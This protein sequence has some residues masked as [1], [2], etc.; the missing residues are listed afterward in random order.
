MIAQEFLTAPKRERLA[1]LRD[2][3]APAIV[4]LFQALVSA[5]D[6]I[7][8][9]LGT[10]DVKMTDLHTVMQATEDYLDLVA[11]LALT[12]PLKTASVLESISQVMSQ[13]GDIVGT[14]LED[15]KPDELQAIVNQWH[16]DGKTITDEDDA[17]AHFALSVVK[18]KIST[19]LTEDAEAYRISLTQLAPSVVE[20]LDSIADV[21]NRNLESH[22]SAHVYTVSI[23]LLFSEMTVSNDENIEIAL[24]QFQPLPESGSLFRF[25]HSLCKLSCLTDAD[26]F[27]S[28]HVSP[29][30]RDAFNYI[31]DMQ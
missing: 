13:K 6:E 9:G 23:A 28:N 8:Q 25:F 11:S 30:R 3:S 4:K 29:L 2:S 20:A 16:E 19:L 15:V 17:E 26:H 31:A 18:T 22:H 1:F 24:I 27:L 10:D 14:E 5:T 7:A 12:H 21:L